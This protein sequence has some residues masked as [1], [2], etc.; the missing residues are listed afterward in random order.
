MQGKQQTVGT[1]GVMKHRKIKKLLTNERNLTMK[2]FWNKWAVPLAT[3][4]GI[5]GGLF[6]FSVI[7]GVL[8]M[9]YDPMTMVYNIARD[10]KEIFG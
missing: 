7:L 3:G 9:D 2:K 8:F 1:V 5:V 10:F 4:I 6:A